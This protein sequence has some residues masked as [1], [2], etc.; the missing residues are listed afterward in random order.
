MLS[1]EMRILF[2][3]LLATRVGPGQQFEDVTAASGVK[4]RHHAGKSPQK[5][6]IETMGSGLAIAD[7]DGD[8]EL[9]LFFVGG[10]GGKHRLYRGLGGLR[11]RELTEAVVGRGYGMGAAAADVDGDGDTDLAVSELDRLVLYRNNGD[12]SFAESVLPGQGW[13]AAPAFLDFDGDERL[14]LFVS[15]Y[16]DWDFERS[17]WC[18]ENEPGRR[19]Y[20]HPREYGPVTHLL[21]RNRGQGG[22][23][24]VSA[25]VG[26]DNHPGKGLGVA[27]NDFDG[28]GWPDVFVA[29]DSHPQQ[30]FRNV[31]GK[32]F[33]EVG[34]GS[35]AAY[36]ADGRDFAGMGAVFEDYDNDGR[37]DIFVDALGRQGYW[38][39]RNLGDGEFEPVSR[40]TGL[41][42]PTEMHSGWGVALTDLD[43]DGWRDL[44]VAQGHV[45]DDIERTDPA[46]AY[47]EP[48]VLLRNLFGRFYD[49]SQQ[50]GEA[51]ARPRA[52]RGAIAADLDGDGRLDL[53]VT[54][55]DGPAV[56]LRNVTPNAGNRIA[57]EA[58]VGSKVR[59]TLESGRELSGYVS[60][61][62]S[63][64]SSGP[65]LVH[66]GLGGSKVQSV[67]IRQQDGRERTIERPKPGRIQR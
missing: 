25:Q 24:D 50:A 42:G 28:D 46:L 32:R 23:E 41:A 31:G 33:E 16:L 20:C 10:A 30:L 39:Y 44:F 14:D 38:L 49:R 37:P 26:L 51:F 7:F 22:F 47:R 18:G 62:G 19:S 15:R 54:T 57:V 29:N 12:A 61:A 1:T 21:L 35:G 13:L 59:V 65:G 2:A 64:L 56:I 5:H 43:N 48:L 6:L 3:L 36:D 63:Y 45:M 53:A 60:T 55:N 58:P 27:V 4:F 11:F 66:F 9:D 40:R 52:A 67:S 8:G 34:V 17:R